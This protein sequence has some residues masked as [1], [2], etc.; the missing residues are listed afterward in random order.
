MGQHEGKMM[1]ANHHHHRSSSSSHTA[2]TTSSSASYSSAHAAPKEA[3]PV[4]EGPH[5]DEEWKSAFLTNDD[6]VRFLADALPSR[7]Y[8]RKWKLLYSSPKHGKSF[9]RFCFHITGQG[10]TII[11]IR[12]SGGAMFGGFADHMWRDKYPKFYG[13][14][15]SFVFSLRGSHG[16]ENKKA[17]RVTGLNDHYQWLN[18]GTMTLFNGVGMGGQEHFFAW[19]IDDNF[20]TGKC[21][22][23]PNTT[24]GSPILSS[25]PDWDVD[26]VEVWEVKESETITY[27]QEKLLKKK[28]NTK[29]VLEDDDNADKVITGMMGHEFSHEDKVPDVKK[30]EGE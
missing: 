14:G 2:A 9:N 25:T 3:L 21:R 4:L 13:E 10:S 12:D 6:V 20:D 16:S 18:Q 24:F 15:S 17:Y 1:E 22:G 5:K 19:S 23:E 11:L 27:E 26:L 29:S 30:K 8:R 28:S 7:E